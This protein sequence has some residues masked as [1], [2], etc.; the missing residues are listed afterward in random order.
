[1]LGVKR[2]GDALSPEF[3]PAVLVFPDHHDD[4]P[5]CY[6]VKPQPPPRPPKL[7][8]LAPGED[9][10]YNEFT[11]R[12]LGQ[13]CALSP[14]Q[15]PRTSRGILATCDIQTPSFSMM[16]EV[17]PMPSEP[18]RKSVRH[19]NDVE[20][21]LVAVM[22]DKRFDVVPV[23]RGANSNNATRQISRVTRVGPLA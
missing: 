14:R 16:S 3:L 12:H 13:A 17:P 1:M 5:E 2:R 15:L 9:P 21:N 10:E 23:E 18:R 19:S 11:V 20:G 8:A 7:G 4:K 6:K 22:Q